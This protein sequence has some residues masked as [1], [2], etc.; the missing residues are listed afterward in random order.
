MVAAKYSR[1]NHCFCFVVF[2]GCFVSSQEFSAAFVNSEHPLKSHSPRDLVRERAEFGYAEPTVSMIILSCFTNVDAKNW[3]NII[4]MMAYIILYAVAYILWC[5]QLM[6]VC[7][8]VYSTLFLDII[9]IFFT[10]FWNIQIH[11]N[12]LFY[13]IYYQIQET[14]FSSVSNILHVLV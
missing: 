3:T 8:D 2:S 13:K 1:E 7:Y 14:S 10:F 9:D 12:M 4:I 5:V 6:S 11:F